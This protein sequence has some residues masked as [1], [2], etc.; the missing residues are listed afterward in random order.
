MSRL[1]QPGGDE[2]SWGQILNDFL[3]QAH[4]ADGTLKDGVV[5]TAK[6]APGAVTNAVLGAGGGTDG[7]VLTKNSSASGGMAWATVAGGGPIPDASATQKGVVQLTGDLGGTAVSPTVPAL[8]NKADSANVYTKT[9]IDTAL[10]AKAD[11]SALSG[12]V[13]T[14]QKGAASGVA[15]LDGTGKVPATQLPAAVS[16]VNADWNAVSGVAQILN[17]PTIPAAQLQSDWNQS[18]TASSDYIKNKPSL[19]AVATSGA[20][21]DL[22]GKPTLATVATSGSYTDLSNQPTIPAAQVQS[23]WNAV[24]GVAQILNKPTIPAAQVSS[25]WNASSGVAQIL[26]KPTIDKT[27]VGLANVDNTSDANKPVSTAQQTALDAKSDRVVSMNAQTATTYTFVLSDSDKL[28]TLT[29]NAAISVTVPT[30]AAAAF[31]VG[32]RI[33]FAQMGAGQVTVVAAGGVA[34]F[35]DPGL[36]IAAQYGAAELFKI[37]TDTWLLVGRL[38]A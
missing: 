16:Q 37:A 38:A 22:T 36:K 12:Y 4:N 35:G 32:T 9:Q 13:P 14:S 31:P 23:D 24:S 28:V 1:P 21:A 3:G 8:A 2:G 25:D 19:S 30:N 34:V 5:G 15:S 10:S 27:A 11:T 33:K 7:Q 26:N 18:A 6:L 29:N 17:K 20:Y